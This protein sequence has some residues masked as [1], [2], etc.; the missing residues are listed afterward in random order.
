[1]LAIGI[2]VP[3]NPEAWPRRAPCTSLGRAGRAG[4]AVSGAARA[5]ATSHGLPARRFCLRGAIECPT[6]LP[7]NW[8]QKIR[9]AAVHAIALARLALT[10]ARGQVE[11]AR[12][13]SGLIERLN[14]EIPQ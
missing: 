1:M 4:K 3:A 9:S 5:G 7:K 8:P 12:S 2:V 6:L 14:E 13:G 11:S 10:T